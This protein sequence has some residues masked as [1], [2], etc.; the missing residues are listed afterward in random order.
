MRNVRGELSAVVKAC[1]QLISAIHS[2]PT[3]TIEEQLLM[4][5]YANRLCQIAEGNGVLRS[6][7]QPELGTHPRTLGPH[8][9]GAATS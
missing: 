5:Y 7:G 3:L 6:D 4:A 9:D 8:D 2:N 1:K